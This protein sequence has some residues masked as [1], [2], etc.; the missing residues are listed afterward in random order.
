M[1]R[2]SRAQSG[3]FYPCSGILY[4]KRRHWE[5]DKEPHQCLG[6][7]SSCGHWSLNLGHLALELIVAASQLSLYEPGSSS[8]ALLC[9]HSCPRPRSHWVLPLG[10]KEP[11]HRYAL[12]QVKP[13]KLGGQSQVPGMVCHHVNILREH[14]CKNIPA[15]QVHRVVQEAALRHWRHLLVCV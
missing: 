8:E 13:V 3:T 14:L 9:S 15:A 7:S 4:G 6:V 2:D 5:H 10:R 11:N 12:Y 1:P